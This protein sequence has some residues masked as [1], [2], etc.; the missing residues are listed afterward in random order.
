MNLRGNPT[1]TRHTCAVLAQQDKQSRQEA[2]VRNLC[3]CYPPRDL[4]CKCSVGYTGLVVGDGEKLNMP[5]E[6]AGQASDKQTPETT[7]VAMLLGQPLI[8]TPLLLIAQFEEQ[9]CPTL[10]ALAQNCI[11]AE[12][13]A[14]GLLANC[15]AAVGLQTELAPQLSSQVG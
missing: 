10:Q 2:R 8:K 15:A 6:L 7:R 11:E 12:P 4:H 3:H 14:K 13:L 1:Y 5:L 9:D